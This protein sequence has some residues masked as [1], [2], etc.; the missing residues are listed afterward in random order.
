[1]SGIIKPIM[2]SFTHLLRRYRL[3]PLFSLYG[4]ILVDAF[5][6]SYQ[7]DIITFGLVG[8]YAL[9]QYLTRGTSRSTF[10]FCLALFLLMY[11]QF[12][13]SGPVVKA[14]KLAVWLYLFLVLG[15][16]QK[17]RE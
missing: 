2:R 10:L 15:V 5:F 6:V 16:I 17:W 12:I 9:V 11:M 7:S 13:F 3:F 8:A 14:E 1:M 4:L